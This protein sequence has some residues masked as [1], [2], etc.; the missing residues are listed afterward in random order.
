MFV[1]REVFEKIGL[2]NEDMGA[3]TEFPCEDIEWACRA[4]LG[5]FEGILIPD[6]IIYH[7]HQ[8]KTNSLEA[9]KVLESYD[10]GRGA[11]YASL[12]TLGYYNSWDLWGNINIGKNGIKSINSIKKLSRELNGAS[13][14]LDFIA[15]KYF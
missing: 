5:G 6:I 11:Y 1:K 8:R 13:R 3:G 4:S 2:F 7:H 9:L 14:Y 15:S 10:V 12:I